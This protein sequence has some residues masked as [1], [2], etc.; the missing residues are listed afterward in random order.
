MG[1]DRSFHCKMLNIVGL[2]PLNVSVVSTP[3]P[4]HRTAKSASLQFNIQGRAEVTLV[5][6]HYAV[7][8][9]GMGRIGTHGS[10]HQPLPIQHIVLTGSRG[11]R[12]EHTIRGTFLHTA[13]RTEPEP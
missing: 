9:Y 11:K 2:Y 12:H 4:I 13:G 1:Q 10:Y 3:T 8:I 6:N 7:V 5:E